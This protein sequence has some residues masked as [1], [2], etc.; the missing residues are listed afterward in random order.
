MRQRPSASNNQSTNQSINQ[1]YSLSWILVREFNRQQTGQEMP[2]AAT[3]ARS[4]ALAIPIQA[5]NQKIDM[6]MAAI[7]AQLLSFLETS[8]SRAAV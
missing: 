6:Q 1:L 7:K 4:C 8:S 5:F 3:H 2:D